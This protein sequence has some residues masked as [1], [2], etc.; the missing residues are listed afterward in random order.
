M[1]VPFDFASRPLRTRYVDPQELV[2]IFRPAPVSHPAPITY[3]TAAKNRFDCPIAASGGTLFGVTYAAFDL[4]TCFAET[5]TREANCKPLF[6]GAIAVSESA[7]ILP[8]FVAT[9]RGT[10]QMRL[11][12]ATDVGL[13]GLGAEAGE[14][15]SVDYA[16]HTQPWALELFKRSEVVDGL[17]YRSRFLNGRLAVAIFDRGGANVGL[18]SAHV[19][20]LNRHPDYAQTLTE[21]GICLL[22]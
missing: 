10:L 18:G 5:I 3:G 7:D 20:P 2:R 17:L 9:L 16:K 14:F 15:N 4:A 22:P 19:V 21:L 6:R 8:R 13:Y 11:A 12:D 1:P